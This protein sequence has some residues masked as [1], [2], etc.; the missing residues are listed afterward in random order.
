MNCQGTVL[1]VDGN[2]AKVKVLTSLE[3]MSCQSRNHCPAETG[4]TRII[5]VIN[6]YGAKVSDYV[7]FEADTGKVILSAILLWIVPLI[8][9]IIGYIA[10]ERFAGGL[11]SIGVALIFLV[12]TFAL[13]KLL[14]SKLSDSS[15]F[16]PFISK[17][18]H[19]SI[20]NGPD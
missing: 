5:T 17:I 14:D 2:K 20:I 10:G 1:S 9:M 13:I 8:A 3:C 7:V 4:G 19:P 11:W 15:T 12:T 18:I 16:Y 6:E